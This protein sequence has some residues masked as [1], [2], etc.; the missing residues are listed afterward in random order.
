MRTAFA[1]LL[2]AYGS[3]LIA[4]DTT[5]FTNYLRQNGAEWMD[6]NSHIEKVMDRAFLQNQLILIGQNPGAPYASDVQF[7]LLKF[8]KQKTNFRY[9]LVERGYLDKIYINRYLST[10]NEAVLDTLIKLRPALVSQEGQS[11]FYRQL[12]VLNR[13]LPPRDKIII[14]PL[15]F[16]FAYP[17]AIHFLK[18]QVFADLPDGYRIA[19]SLMPGGD[20]I[21]QVIAPFRVAKEIFQAR[22]KQF[23]KILGLKFEDA[24]GLFRSLELFF[25]NRLNNR[26][27]LHDSIMSL[28]LQFYRKSDHIGRA[29]MVGLFATSHVKQEDHP[30]EPRFAAMVGRKKDVNG[31]ASVVSVYNGLDMQIRTSLNPAGISRPVYG[32]PMDEG[33]NDLPVKYGQLLGGFTRPKAM[34]F[35]LDRKNSPFLHSTAFTVPGD[36]P[37]TTT[38][39]FQVLILINPFPATRSGTET[40]MKK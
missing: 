10:G 28:N 32:S 7:D 5:P 16:E 31:I 26:P 33:V 20:S 24:A 23:R 25:A 39:L 30:G 27:G 40:A 37:F 22:E 29:H 15:D 21:E 38:K 36:E 4:Q 35:R 11:R 3:T 1:F 19:D 34:L 13:S 2:L 8:L 14:V 12:Y 18:D 17:E 9:L 6:G